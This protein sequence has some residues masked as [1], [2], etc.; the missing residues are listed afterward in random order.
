[1]ILLWHG[2]FFFGVKFLGGFNVC[3]LYCLQVFGYVI[4]Y[5]FYAHFMHFTRIQP[6]VFYFHFVCV[7]FNFL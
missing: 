3:V 5:G 2:S 6:F 4:I 7:G 1:M